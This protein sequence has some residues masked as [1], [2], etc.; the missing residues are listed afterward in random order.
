MVNALVMDPGTN[1][2]LTF[3]VP[4]MGDD[5]F[6][7]YE[8]SV[9]GPVSAPHSR[10]AMSRSHFTGTSTHAHH[11]L[12]T[13]KLPV[14]SWSDLF[15]YREGVTRK[16]RRLWPKIVPSSR[17]TVE[18]IH[19]AN[20]GRREVRLFVSVDG[21]MTFNDTQQDFTIYAHAMAVKGTC[22]GGGKCVS[23]A[24]FSLVCS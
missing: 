23:G 16:D 18:T 1:S 10:A 21:G 8:L 20:A 5:F 4:C 14:R 19:S 2:V 11:L 15:A 13:R 3:R 12:D 9:S 22:S 6:D 7:G 17:T 24:W